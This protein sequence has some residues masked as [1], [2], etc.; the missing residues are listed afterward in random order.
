M[1]KQVRG[2]YID[3]WLNVRVEHVRQ[4]NTRS[5]WVK[6]IQENDKLKAAANKEKKRIST[7]RQVPGPRGERTVAVDHAKI[8][9]RTNKPFIELH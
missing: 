9:I 2:Q 3:K 6:R 8:A 5:S 4:S 1:L 7:K